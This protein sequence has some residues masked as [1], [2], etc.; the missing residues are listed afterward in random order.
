MWMPL[1]DRPLLSYVT[2]KQSSG[3]PN[4]ASQSVPDVHVSVLV[5]AIPNGPLS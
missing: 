3:F 1:H 2:D 4:L 5:P